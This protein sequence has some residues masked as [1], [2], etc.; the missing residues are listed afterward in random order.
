MEGRGALRAPGIPWAGG[1]ARPPPTKVR[2]C[3]ARPYDENKMISLILRWLIN[4]GALFL[5]TY[6]VPGVRVDS[7]PKLF[8]AALVLGLLNAIVR[9]VLFW[10]TLPLTILTLGLFILV[11]NGIML[12]LT[13]WLVPGFGIDGFLSAVLGALILSIVGFLTSWIGKDRKD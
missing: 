3:A 9:P 11:L 2:A 8:I 6:I 13:A 4:T 1:V 10:L 7:T 5:V 12:S